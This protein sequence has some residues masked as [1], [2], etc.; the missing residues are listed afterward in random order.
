MSGYLDK[1]YALSLLE[2][3]VPVKLNQS[4]S[5][6]LERPIARSGY[7]DAMGCYPIFSCKDWTHLHKDLKDIDNNLVAFS[8]VTDPLANF[9]LNELQKTFPDVCYPYKSHYV[10]SLKDYKKHIIS[11]G[12]QRNVQKAQNL[13]TL[14]RI[15]NPKKYLN[16]WM[17]LYSA[18]INRHKINGIARFSYNSFKLQFDTLGFVVYTASFINKIVGMVLFFKMDGGVY[19]HLG[20]YDEDGYANSASFGIFWQAI[21]DFAAEG[22]SWLNLGSGAG[23]KAKSND[24]LTRFKKGWSSETRTAYFCGKVFDKQ[25]YDDL[26]SRYGQSD[27]FF[28]AYRSGI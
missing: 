16:K 25:I 22:L 3:G 21:Q 2:Y 24:G 15:D 9:D 13:L 6:I 18:L 1:L 28:P 23:L 12:H 11:K 4:E 26:N 8:M 19:Y 20:A 17:E 27:H 7:K 5:W 14:E 10:I